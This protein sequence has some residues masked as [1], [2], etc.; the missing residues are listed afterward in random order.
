[1]RVRVVRVV[2]VVRV[3]RVRGRV[4]RITRRV[5]LYTTH[6]RAQTVHSSSEDASDTVTREHVRRYARNHVLIILAAEVCVVGRSY[7][8]VT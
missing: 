5:Q 4:Q 3:V 1:M 7:R 6:K 2:Q 8:G